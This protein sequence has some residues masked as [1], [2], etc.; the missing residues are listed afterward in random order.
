MKIFMNIAIILFP[1]L[2]SLI[3]AK[4]NQKE[5]AYILCGILTLW[6]FYWF[7]L[8]SPNSTW[9]SVFFVAF[10]IAIIAGGL[11]SIISWYKREKGKK[12]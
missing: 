8:Q 6:Y 2:V 3:G 5:D 11:I 7:T 4:K 9:Q 12:G 1:L 10:E